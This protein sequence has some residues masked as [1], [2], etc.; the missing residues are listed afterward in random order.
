MWI[1]AF[2]T[3]PEDTGAIHRIVWA[4][5]ART[6]GTW[7]EKCRILLIAAQESPKGKCVKFNLW[8]ILN[9]LGHCQFCVHQRS[10]ISCKTL[11]L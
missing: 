1:G 7:K 5:N 2:V 10:N 9:I 4:Y 8:K 11:K 3:N 6:V